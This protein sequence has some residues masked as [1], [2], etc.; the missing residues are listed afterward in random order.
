MLHRNV[1]RLV[2]R[3]AA[4]DR[5][6]RVNVREVEPLA[7]VE[8]DELD[9]V[10]ARGVVHLAAVAARVDESVEA[11]AR[12]HPGAPCGGFAAH[13]E[14]N[15]GRNVVRRHLVRRDHL[16]DRRRRHRRRPARIGAGDHGLQQAPA[17]DVVDALDAVHVAGG[18]RQEEGQVARPALAGEALADRREHPVGAR[19]PR[20]R[21]RRDDRAV[22]DEPRG[23]FERDD[24]RARHAVTVSYRAQP[25]PRWPKSKTPGCRISARISADSTSRGPGRLKY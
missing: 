4:D 6:L 25:L 8:L 10:R 23:L 14:E 16:P 20:R 3:G 24:L 5:D 2:R 7:A 19:E 22:R 17:R 18:D 1:A 13:V 9:D 15:A 11:H 12:H 21:A